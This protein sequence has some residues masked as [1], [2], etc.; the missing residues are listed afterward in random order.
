MG[1]T[2]DGAIVVNTLGS[3]TTTISDATLDVTGAVSTGTITLDHAVLNV[4]ESMIGGSVTLNSSVMNIGGASPNASR[5][6]ITYGSGVSAVELADIKRGANNAPK[7]LNL[8]NGDSIAESNVAFNSATWARNTLTLKENGTTV[9]RFTD[10]TLNP[11][12]SSTTFAASTEVIGGVTYYVATL[13]PAAGGVGAGVAGPTG[14]AGSTGSLRSN[15][16]SPA[17]SGTSELSAASGTTDRLTAAIHSGNLAGPQDQAFAP[18]FLYA[19]SGTAGASGQPATTTG[20]ALDVLVRAGT[21]YVQNFSLVQGDKLDLKQILA[22]APLAHDLANIA[23]FV[24]VTGHGQND[25]GFGP[26][27]KTSLEVTGPHGS[28][29]VNLEGAGKLELKDLLQHN[30]LLLPPH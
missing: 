13:D 12:H 23:N 19:G 2:G 3:G 15:H 20:P 28:A 4:S 16:G 8:N 21:A 11:G 25:P 18:R 26:G 14:P 7:L 29:L 9:A 10:V 30:S 6:S 24:K 5:G 22:G 27:T 1:P 17:T